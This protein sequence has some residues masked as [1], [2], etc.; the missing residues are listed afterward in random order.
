MVPRFRP[1]SDTRCVV[2]AWLVQPSNMCI[3]QSFHSHLPFCTYSP[4][5]RASKIVYH[6]FTQD[7]KTLD[8]NNLPTIIH[9]S[10]I[11]PRNNPM[12]GSPISILNFDTQIRYPVAN[13]FRL[14]RYRQ[15]A[16]HPDW[17]SHTPIRSK[18]PD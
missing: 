15:S 16:N 3:F 10:K 18:S 17:V 5:Q 9:N 4:L 8:Q 2:Q 1:K 13:P 7:I 11:E 6:H 12:T 14:G